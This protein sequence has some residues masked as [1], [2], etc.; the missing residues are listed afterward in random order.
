MSDTPYKPR[1][2]DTSRIQL[3]EDVLGLAE[4]FAEN[5]HE[6]WARE[7]VK[8]GWTYGTH[9]DDGT[10]Q[11]PCLI[12]YKD[13][14]DDERAMDQIA[15]IE[16]IK[17]LIS[18][19]YRKDPS[20]SDALFLDQKERDDQ[21]QAVLREIKNPKITTAQLRQLWTERIPII[22][23]QD[24]EI[25]R[26][27]TDV[28]LKQG[29]G[30][31]AFDIAD[32]GIQKFTD[33]LRLLQLQALALART[34]ATRRANAI[35]E[36]LSQSGHKDEETLGILAR[37]YK[38]FWQLSTDPDESKEHLR[39]SY[40]LY[41]DA[42]DRNG[43]Y[44]S[45]INAAT[46]GLIFGDKS[47]AQRLAKEVSE[48]CSATLEYISPDSGERYWLEATLA[49]ALLIMGDFDGAEE[50]YR[51]GSQDGDVGSV[52]LSRTRSQARI[53]L[54]H[55]GE[56]IHLLDKCF[57]LPRIAVFS[58][59]MFDRPDRET[60]RFPHTKEPEVREKI[61]TFLKDSNVQAGYSS[62]ACGADQ[63]FAEALLDAGGE[64]NIVLPFHVADFKIA[65]V[66][67]Y[68][69]NEWSER[70]DKVLKRAATV[71]I[72][73]ELGDAQDSAAFDFCNQAISGMALLKSQFLGMDVIPLFVW[74]GQRGDGAGGTQACI[75]YWRNFQ[76]SEVEIIHVG[77]TASMDS[78]PTLEGSDLKPEELNAESVELKE[79]EMSTK[80]EIRAM[81]FADVVGFTKLT[82]MQ[83][84]GFVKNFLGQ[85]AEIM[86]NLE[87]PPLYHNTW[88]DAVMCVFKT[89]TDAGIFA[90]KLRDLVR[91][92]DWSQW[93]LPELSIRIALHCGP[94]FPCY[95]PVLK[96]RTFNGAHV[97]RT[98]RIE[99]VAEEGQIYSSE[100]FAAIATADGVEE[101][102][103]DYVGT[104]QLAKKY[105]AIPVFLVRETAQS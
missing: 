20:V 57:T 26:R 83:I 35:L 70:F 8:Q 58:G 18:L 67:L 101:F 12:P 105:G 39:R 59:H 87:H 90:L 102:I 52:V 89:V 92:S 100:A 95:D 17:T 45:G 29:E 44:Y 75:D 10:K 13:L 25:Y 34:G 76:K 55:L 16:T 14:S 7:R 31:V 103:C 96:K 9:R 97:N 50:F 48:I 80:Q 19:G 32:E 22:W 61:D 47:N 82:E 62:L 6:V 64:V 4:V 65:S 98:A 91:G 24:V 49:E 66:D 68:P 94:V 63:I 93:D 81:V 74:D 42:Y 54:K 77:D 3:S 72:L 21:A 27:A 71:T 84:P 99:P 60:P 69:G 73:S 1:P 56:D 2:L 15:A 41:A 5:N 88:G 38:D 40:E 46:T 43:G 30:F 85:V 53:I 78:G 37:T 28:A 33:D 79:G 51:R 36:Q 86:D 104:K 23:S 11:H